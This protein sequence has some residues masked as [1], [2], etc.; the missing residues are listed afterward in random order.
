MPSRQTM[1]T[2]SEKNIVKKIKLSNYVI[3]K[4]CSPKKQTI[5]YKD[6]DYFW[7]SKLTFKKFQV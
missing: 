3:T 6:S 7:Q 4:S 2:I 1:D 5:F